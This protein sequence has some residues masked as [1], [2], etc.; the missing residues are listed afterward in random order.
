MDYRK[1]NDITCKDFYLLPRIDD[2]I[3]ALSKQNTF[4]DLKSGYWQ[5]PLD[6]SAKEKTA[7][8]TGSGLWQFKVMPSGAAS[9]L[10]LD[11]CT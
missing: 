2:T 9:R 8:S 6:D 10:M 3:E 1:L 11:T 4:L 7:F 5:V